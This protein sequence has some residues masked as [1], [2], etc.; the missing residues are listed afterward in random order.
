M[1]KVFLGIVF[2]LT[3]IFAL[4][5]FGASA[6][7]EGSAVYNADTFLAMTPGNSY[8]LTN[9]IDLGGQTFTN[10]IF[11]E[12]H[13]KIDGNGYSVYNF[14]ITGD[15]NNASDV[16]MI[17]R[18]NK[19]GDLEICD[20]NI[21]TADN[22]VKVVN[23]VVSG[24]SNGVLIG[25]NQD[26]YSCT[27]RNISIYADV[28]SPI[29]DSAKTNLGGFVG[30]CRRTTF[31]NCKM[32]GSIVCGG[33]QTS[34][35]TVYRNAGGIVGAIKG[36]VVLTNCE[37]HADIV[38]GPSSSE[39]RAAG[40]AAY[41]DGVA[42]VITGCKNYGNITC[43]DYEDYTKYGWF[44]S[45]SYCAGIIGQINYVGST[46]TDC[47]NHGKLTGTNATA[48]IL[49]NAFS[50]DGRDT[51]THTITN[52][53]NTGTYTGNALYVGEVYAKSHAVAEVVV[54]GCTNSGVTEDFTPQ[55]T[56]KETEPATP[57]ETTT[58]GAVD[59]TTVSTPE[60]TTTPAT[61][62]TTK[63]PEETTTAAQNVDNTEKK[64]CGGVAGI[65]V[66]LTVIVS[67]FGAAVIVKKN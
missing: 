14:T 10:Y 57:E 3:L 16:A 51:V 43:L 39:A 23:L 26:A 46:I 8:Y 65:A 25:A 31:E 6:A 22:H 30:Y 17:L 60:E 45:D 40:I 21:G 58:E 5:I 56:V 64:G 29:P 9:D 28:E 32:Y 47:E 36:E 2:S 7:Q 34:V 37:N 15:A 66:A 67:S 55:T 38:N 20:I 33:G 11:S 63:A 49:A 18:A 52:C 61:I 27:L 1:K 41:A 50:A 44:S 19:S 24:K 53:T 4:A 54:S 48:P 35:A 13:G 62:T 12:F 59:E 42:P